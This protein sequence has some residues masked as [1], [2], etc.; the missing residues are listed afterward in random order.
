MSLPIGPCCSQPGGD[1]WMCPKNCPIATRGDKAN[2]EDATAPE[3]GHKP[4]PTQGCPHHGLC[5]HCQGKSIL[6]LPNL[7]LDSPSHCSWDC[8][9]CVTAPHGGVP[10]KGGTKP[11]S[12][13]LSLASAKAAEIALGQQSK[14]SACLRLNIPRAGIC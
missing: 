4:K 1:N 2:P 8:P 3:F 11:S 6:F 7:E 12:V 5:Q 13:L 14:K 10:A 9:H